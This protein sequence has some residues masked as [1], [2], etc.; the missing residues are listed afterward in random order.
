MPQPYEVIMPILVD[1]FGG[2]MP[3]YAAHALPNECARVAENCRL[4]S[5]ALELH[6]TPT[7]APSSLLLSEMTKGD[8][9]VKA[10]LQT[11]KPRLKPGAP[12]FRMASPY[13]NKGIFYGYKGDGSPLY[14]SDLASIYD[15]F[16]PTAWYYEMR[17]DENG[18]WADSGWSRALPMTP[19]PM[20]DD[21]PPDV[22][23]T[24]DGVILTY[25]MDSATI[26]RNGLLGNS[27]GAYLAKGPIYQFGLKGN[28][29]VVNDRVVVGGADPAGAIL[30]GGV[31][32][33]G[34]FPLY[35]NKNS[36]RWPGDKI[37][38]VYDG[39]VYGQLQVARI[40]GPLWDNEFFVYA[41]W[42]ANIVPGGLVTLHLNL[43]YTRSQRLHVQYVTCGALEDGRIGPPSEMSDEIHVPPGAMPNLLLPL[44]GTPYLNVYRSSSG[45]DGFRML[46]EK[47]TP[48]TG[49]NAGDDATPVRDGQLTPVGAELPPFGSYYEDETSQ[50]NKVGYPSTLT[51]IVMHP[52]QFAVGV[53]GQDKKV[54]VSDQYKPHVWP[55]EWAIP[56]RDTP[57]CAVICGGSAVVFTRS[58]ETEGGVYAIHG[59][60]P[61]NL[62]VALVS[63]TAPLYK[64][65]LLGRIGDALYWV[66]VD[67]LARYSGGRVE[68][69]TADHYTREEWNY[70]R[71]AEESLTVAEQT[72]Y[73]GDLLKFDLV[74]KTA[75][76]S[77]LTP[78]VDLT[79]QSKDFVFEQPETIEFIRVVADGPVW[80]TLYNESGNAHASEIEVN[81]RE[82]VDVSGLLTAGREFGRFWAFKLRTSATVYSVQ[83][84][85]RQVFQ[86]TGNVLDVDASKVKTWRRFWVKFPHLGVLSGL[87]FSKQMLTGALSARVTAI[88]DGVPDGIVNVESTSG[89]LMVIPRYGWSE[90]DGT[91]TSVLMRSGLWKIELFTGAVVDET[92][93]DI[94]SD[95]V[96]DAH[97]DA[98][99]VF[100]REGQAV[101]GES[102][103]EINDGRIPPWLLKRY[104]FT[105]RVKLR[106]IAF[107]AL[108]DVQAKINLYVDGASEPV[109]LTYP[110]GKELLAS[111]DELSLRSLSSRV[112]AIE[113][114]FGGVDDNVLSVAM[115]FGEAKM[116]GSEGVFLGNAASMTGLHFKFPDRGKF[117][118]V[119]MGA[120]SYWTAAD[121]YP[122]ITLWGDGGSGVEEWPGLTAAQI[123]RAERIENGYAKRLPR[124]LDES[125]EWEFEIDHPKEV[126]NVRLWPLVRQPVEAKVIHEIAQDTEIPP[127]M[128]RRYEFPD[129]AIPKSVKVHADTAVRMRIYFDGAETHSFDVPISSG[130]EMPITANLFASCV[131]FDFV[132]VNTGLSADYLVNEVF[133]FMRDGMA[134]DEN[135][136][137]LR[138]RLD[139]LDLRVSW[140]DKVVPA[141]VSLDAS[142]YTGAQVFIR[143]NQGTGAN[144]PLSSAQAV[145]IPLSTALAAKSQWTIDASAPGAEIYGMDVYVWKTEQLEKTLHLT[146]RA[147]EV[148]AWMYTRWELLA[149]QRLR[150]VLVRSASAVTLRVWCDDATEPVMFTVSNN[151]VSLMDL[152]LCSSFVFDFNG[153][154][155]LVNEIFF[156]SKEA[157]PVGDEGYHVVEPVSTRMVPLQFAEPS[158]FALLQVQADA[159][160]AVKL[161]SSDGVLRLGRDITDG[162]WLAIPRDLPVDT[163]WVLDVECAANVRAI[164]LWTRRIVPVEGKMLR[165]V[166]Q[167]Q[168]L[169]P[170]WLYE[171]YQFAQPVTLRSG[172]VAATGNVKMLLYKNREVS[173]TYNPSV[174]DENEF[175]YQASTIAGHADIEGVSCVEFDFDEDDSSVN[176]V[177]LFAV[178]EVPVP[179]AGL[180]L[181]GVD[182]PAWRNMN[183]LFPNEGNWSS[184]RLVLAPGVSYSGAKVYLDDTS[185]T[186]SNDRDFAISAVS[187]AAAH[188]WPLDV[189]ADGDVAELHLIARNPATLTNGRVL[190]R[191][192][193][194]PWSWLNR[195]FTCERP[196]SIT[197]GR[198]V[199]KSF[200]GSIGTYRCVVTLATEGETVLDTTVLTSQPFRVPKTTPSRDWRFSVV[201]EA[202]VQI[203]EVSFATSMGGLRYGD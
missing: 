116:V 62:S 97:L 45:Q 197:C 125:A 88:G 187:A 188:S 25:L 91:G 84:V 48:A 186:A 178:E 89:R 174:T 39:D 76:V 120:D 75:A 79:W 102:F 175:I 60:N 150:S 179:Q 61:A 156:F 70:T 51:Q 137:H 30:G 182:R 67:G 8:D 49:T 68:I 38:L 47:F 83:M 5:G 153:D 152:P 117:A 145:S 28:G 151:E 169:P 161:Y 168:N 56:F 54:Y 33:A 176:S 131:E 111:G 2:L 148:P 96:G 4:T 86:M 6:V 190:V 146:R 106:S 13:V 108:P 41:D 141:C 9:D 136:V 143:D 114:D 22:Q 66:T 74:G 115:Y 158:G 12:W 189:V 133:V 59:S 82:W 118:V 93:E 144:L 195:Y 27:A 159:S 103:N 119:S 200:A 36:A 184:G 80:V 3:R 193:S 85:E 55:E 105:D 14:L 77:E 194:E 198:L 42:P 167:S 109:S 57:S 24:E 138:D 72:V 10:I 166:R 43:N 202:G 1:K 40:D 73:I 124:Q 11:P 90:P 34:L 52:A 123:L 170:Q 132:D 17:Q 165:V 139:W 173:W 185:Y 65:T 32:S 122:K 147:G 19:Y 92:E 196:I 7:P 181:R 15:W 199:A 155:H 126:R 46:R 130:N 135:G 20:Q 87:S 78:A 172:L 192:D 127:W 99:T 71:F 104:I 112:S 53:S 177:S 16:V 21:E 100:A 160:A 113:F 31:Y 121:P 23:F 29:T 37:P 203:L 201:A 183:L 163:N 110:D 35:C 50:T 94:V 154:D 58:S 69:V 140:R 164:H 129:R 98:V 134:G 128:N 101:D 157:V 81:S 63:E 191:R 44:R 18:Q 180:I 95:A 26:P 142:A 149:S 171:V 64:D 162:G 107:N